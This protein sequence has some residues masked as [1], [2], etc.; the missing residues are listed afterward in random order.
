VR[1][2]VRELL[3]A[4]R[5]DRRDGGD[6]LNV[7]DLRRRHVEALQRRERRPRP[8]LPAPALERVEQRRLLAADV[9][10]GAAVHDDLHVAE[11]PGGARVFDR[12]LQ[13][14]VL[15][16]VLAADV[17][18]DAL[19]EDRV[20]G[21]QTALD[22]PVRD[23]PHDLAVLERARLGL[24][25]IHDEVRR[26]C[27]AAVDQARLA[28][29]REPGAAAA[30]QRGRHEVLDESV[31]VDRQ[32]LRQC[33]VASDSAVLLEPREVPLVRSGQ[34]ELTRRHGAPP[35]AQGRPRA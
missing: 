2:D 30:S 12:A 32:R 23:A 20:R 14:L 16:Q 10:A 34:Q 13:H 9:R 25:R 17:D 11:E 18:E 33:L 6:R 35:R 4:H 7:V 21:D 8:R 24:V 29:G 26:P 22:Q 19:R 28:S 31:G 5:H 3:G 1:P 15:G 27:S